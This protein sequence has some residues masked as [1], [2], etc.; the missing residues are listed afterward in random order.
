[1]VWSYSGSP[2]AHNRDLVRFLV[3]DTL[4]DEQLV[5]D[6][7]IDYVLTQFA[8]ARQAAA[9]V[10]DVIARGFARQ[11]NTKTP[12][13]SVDFTARAKEYRSLAV[14]LRR[15]SAELGAIP[16]AGGISTADKDAQEALTDR[17]QPAF[18]TTLHMVPGATEELTT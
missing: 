15:E 7:E 5:T 11:A 10:A 8:D 13:L 9:Q 18:T 16:Y 14:A 2:G 12:E 1:M 3:Q 4:E 17:V 6:E